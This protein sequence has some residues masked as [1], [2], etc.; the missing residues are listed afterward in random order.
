MGT[1][2][3]PKFF[4]N[5][6][7]SLRRKRED[8]IDI[9]TSD[10]RAAGNEV[11]IAVRKWLGRMLPDVVSVGHGH[12]IDQESNISPQLDC[13]LRDRSHLPTLFTAEDGTE[14]T[15]FDSI[16][17]VGEIKS[18]YYKN[19]KYIQAFS[20]KLEAIDS[21]L[22]RNVVENTAYGGIKD[23]SLLHHILLGSSEPYLNQLFTFMLFVDS[24]DAT[25]DE[26]AKIY[27]T[28]QDDYLPDIAVFLNGCIVIKATMEDNVMKI[29]K[30]HKQA[31]T[32]VTWKIIPAWK[33]EN[34]EATSEGMHLGFL[35]YCLLN[36][37]RGSHLEG[38]NPTAY[39]KDLLIGSKSTI[40]PI[41]PQQNNAD[42]SAGA[43]R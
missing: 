2:S 7:K 11:E 22:K 37:I 27:R 5:E 34:S 41:D 19:S 40:I 8:C 29:Y 12:I 1:L 35:Y 38:P 13:I 36:N 32:E 25:T 20:K 10:I 3:I 30:Y 4:S 28:T 42:G 6:A 31:P 39:L 33:I 18:T 17:A 43:G 23:N 9:H 15:P 26:I 24:G 16:Y 21:N 14:Y